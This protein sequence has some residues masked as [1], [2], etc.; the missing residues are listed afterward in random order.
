VG[1]PAFPAKHPRRR[2]TISRLEAHLQPADLGPYYLALLEVSQ[3]ATVTQDLDSTVTS[4]SPAAQRIFG[5]LSE[6][7]VGRKL[8]ELVAA[9]PE[10]QA[11]AIRLSERV[12]RQGR[13]R[14][15]TR[16]TRKDGTLVD[17][18][19]VAAPVLADGEAV[20]YITMYHDLSEQRRAEEARRRAENRYLDLIERLPLTV[21]IDRI[22]EVSSN[23][24]TS[25]QLESVLGYTVEEW[26]S[27]DELFVKVLHPDD[28][29]RVLAAHFR[30]RDTGEPFRM[31]Y[32]MIAKDGTVRWFLDQAS[33]VTDEQTGLPAYH[34][35]FLL[36]ITE[37]KELEEA[38]RAAEK[39]YRHLVEELPLAVYIDE[40][41][42]E[43]ASY[44]VSPQIEEMFGY[45]AEDWLTDPELF[46]KLLHPEDRE[47]VLADHQR[48]FD[49]GQS[50][51]QF[52]YRLIARGGRTVWV[53][54]EAVIVK[55]EQK[56]L[57][58]QGFLVDITERRLAEQALRESEEQLRRQKQYFQSLVEISPTAVVTLDLEERVTSWNPAAEQLFGWN[59]REAVGRKIGDLVLGTA[60]LRE[61]GVAV[62]ETASQAG[63]AHLPTR[64]S[65]K[66]GSLVDVEV[67]MVPLA[68]GGRPSG[69]YVIYHD[70][71]ELQR[72]RQEA[73]AAT[74][75]KSIFLATMSHEIRTPMN[76]VIGMTELLLDTELDQEQRGFA[77][78]IR[79]SGDALLRVIDDV[80]DFSKI[81]SGKLVLERRPF[82]L[83]E[84][85]ESVLE[86]VAARAA[87]KELELG[88]LIDSDVPPEI[89]GDATRLRQV[90][91]N[92]VSNAV[93]FT[94]QGEVVVSVRRAGSERG[95]HRL[96]VAVRD[97]GIGI[98][99]GR[100]DQL[101]QSFSQVDASTSRRF[102]GTGLGL[103]ISKRLSELMGG[104][105]W[106]E[107][108]PGHGSTFHFTFVAEEAPVPAPPHAGGEQPQLRGKRLLVVDD[109]ATNREIVV[110]HA[111]SW[112]MLSWATGQP[113]EALSWV[114]RGNRFDIAILDM[115][116]PEM[117][118]LALAGRIRE[119]PTGRTLPLVLLS[120]LGRKERGH[121]AREFA[122]TVTKPV[123][124]SQLYDALVG[125]L[126]QGIEE[127]ERVEALAKAAPGAE[128]APTQS[129]LRILVAEDN[130]VNQKLALGMLEK[131]G[132]EADVVANGLEALEAVE[133]GSYDVVLMDV[134]M[135]EV[136]GL[137]AARR[138]RRR[139]PHGPPRIIAMTANALQE[140]R[141][142]CFAAGMDQYL[143]KPIRLAQLAEALTGGEPVTERAPP[144]DSGVLDALREQ[145]GDEAFVRDLVDTFLH[146][147]PAL[148]ADLRSGSAENARR[149]AH[150][151]KTNARTLG[152]AELGRLC[153]ELEQLGTDG[154]AAGEL[155]ARTDAEY[156]RVESALRAA[157]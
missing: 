61:E 106:A 122:V 36:D 131:L 54:D 62:T 125:I 74:Q 15:V 137:E 79:T 138:I 68:V 32:R 143:A 135:P 19:V 151:L 102:G 99:E 90:L 6:E 33:V 157:R 130:A 48:V 82:E 64:R 105:M 1:S 142:A 70:I 46:P 120:S 104:T 71:G 44:Y 113:G 115:Q 77:E 10:L 88:C 5:Y 153:E 24:Y 3:V 101:F 43:A 93:K 148:V 147:A 52:E 59:E 57:Y 41:T 110:R 18:E 42:P 2:R 97:T 107:S 67:L 140:D 118:G 116:M 141:E 128:G 154:E 20:G 80:L 12:A 16:R 28:R 56:P 31:E 4:W 29:E 117:D 17:V 84:C 50:R 69:F 94:E 37:R 65:R 73:E 132:H 155:V 111:R 58:V 72:A 53:R 63:S 150:T 119:L 129:G 45:P 146:E 55:D 100:M 83:R 51:W 39:R 123:R 7:A 75:A 49:A 9:T 112:G 22:D 98:P 156:A 34:H 60:E 47:R 149:A 108:A 109:N 35:G 38:L 114:Q 86:L 85:V 91:I 26:T 95:G 25:P 21:Y 11:E 27:D 40:P 78:V 89:T 136:D 139:R 152:A 121:G 76:A 133:G 8:D 66:D 134:Q 13:T 23:V 127:P 92:L 96:H 30:T 126:A 87:G 14:S 144:L 145:F 124:A 81:E 103:A